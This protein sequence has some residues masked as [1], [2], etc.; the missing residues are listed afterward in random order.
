ME[1]HHYVPLAEQLR[2]KQLDE[3]VGQ[4]HLLGAHG[5]LRQIIE[6]GAPESLIFW[7]PPGTGKTTLARIMALEMQADFIELS[8]VTSGKKDIIATVEQAEFNRRLG[9]RTLLFVDE[10]HRFNKAQQDAFLPHIESGL[11]TLIGATTENP[12]F[13]IITALLSRSRVLTLQPL[14]RD[15]LIVIITRALQHKHI[16]SAQPEAIEA[17]ADVAAGDARIALGVLE[18]ALKLSGNGRAAIT[19]ELVAQAAATTTPAYDKKGEAHY[20]VISAFIKSMRG[21]DVDAALYYLARMLQAGEDPLFIARRMVI[22]ASEDIGLAGNGAL[23]LA[24]SG[25]QAV[26]AIGLP[27]GRYVLFHVATAL[28]KSKKSRQTTDL[29]HTAEARAQQFPNASVPLHLRNA[30]TTLLQQFGYGDGY[31]WQ[32]GFVHPDGFLPAEVAAAITEEANSNS[33]HSSS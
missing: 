21:S 30:E 12:S 22:F 29:M 8:A 4:P 19:P 5:V 20:A 14:S 3:V 18:L 23:G 26:Q 33:N 2:P 31:R 11:I 24:V 32:A 17:I 10:I 28:A 15:E 16:T 7:G 9:K 27:E 13:E 25:F 1:N 6:S